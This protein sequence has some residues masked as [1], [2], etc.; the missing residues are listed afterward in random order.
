ME[1]GTWNTEHPGVLKHALP[2]KPKRMTSKA[3]HHTTDD[4]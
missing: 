3:R 4:H 1:H 2:P